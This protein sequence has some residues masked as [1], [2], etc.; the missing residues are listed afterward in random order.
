M[1]SLV[2]LSVQH[3]VVYF[4]QVVVLLEF[5]DGALGHAVGGSPTLVRVQVVSTGYTCQPS[6]ALGDPVDLPAMYIRLAWVMSAT[7]AYTTSKK[8]TRRAFSRLW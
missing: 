3:G 2:P 1:G 5:L 7:G 8:A 4:S 6:R